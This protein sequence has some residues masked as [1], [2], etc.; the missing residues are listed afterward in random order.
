MVADIDWTSSMQQTFEFYKVDPITWFDVEKMDNILSATIERDLDAETLGSCTLD[1]ENINGEFYVRI[2]LIAIQ[3]GRRFRI[4]LGTYL[5]QTTSLAF[6]GKRHL[7]SVDAYTPLIEL[8]EKYP[9]IGYYIPYDQ[10]ILTMI[11]HMG[12][13]NSRL[14]F[15][16]E[17]VVFGENYLQGNQKGFVADLDDTWLKY[18][19]ELA[20][21]L[22]Y[23]LDLDPK[24]QI[25]LVPIEKTESMKPIWTYTDDNSSI[26]EAD[27]TLDRDLYGIPNVVEILYSSTVGT[28]AENWTDYAY[29]AIAENTDPNSPT[30]IP[31]RGRRII[32][33]ENAPSNYKRNPTQLK[34][35]AKQVLESLS[36][37]E[38]TLKYK[39]GYCPVRVGDCIRFDYKSAGYH[40]VKAKVIR[41]SIN[42][43]SG[44]SVTETAVFTTNLW[45]I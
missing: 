38:C 30:S 44:C 40:N 3:N 32:H 9:P 7:N 24:G 8:K 5:V 23:R 26:L 43:S 20:A 6:D 14:Q 4:A 39:H 42:C 33:R 13:E 12:R 15:P 19:S 10:N 27:V 45:R 29:M 18:L 16:Q 35:Y 17:N 11:L 37:I 21:S 28:E 25:Y 22:N 1:G 41:Q 2:Y 34:D 36:S 31:S